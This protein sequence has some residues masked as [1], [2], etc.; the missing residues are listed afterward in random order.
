M[1]WRQWGLWTLRPRVLAGVLLVELGTVGWVVCAA[2]T[3]PLPTAEDWARLGALAAAALAH[4]QLSRRAEERRRS[5]GTKLHID[6]LSI[7]T[8][9]AALLLPIPLVAVLIGLTRW[10]RHRIARKPTFKAVLTG[11]SITLAACSAHSLTQAAGALERGGLVEGVVVLAAA[12]V[13]CVQQLLLIGVVILLEA[14]QRPPLSQVFGTP[15]QWREMYLAISLGMAVALA[16]SH[17][18]L[19]VVMVGVG[20]AINRLAGARAQAEQAVRLAQK[21]AWTDPLTQV[22]N[23]AGWEHKA[24]DGLRQAALSGRPRAVVLVDLDHFKKVNDTLGHL[25]GDEVLQ[26]AAQ[27]I[28]DRVRGGDQVARFGGEEFVVALP[29]ADVDEARQVAERLLQGIRDVRVLATRL[30]GGDPVIVGGADWPCTASIGVAVTASDTDPAVLL[31]QADEAMYEAKHTGRNKV[32]V[33][34][35]PRRTRAGIA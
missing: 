5:D 10:Q 27:A 31:K 29:D 28:A 4:V 13:F 2:L 15:R 7:W 9:P 22:L 16:H 32:V 6:V 33:A 3:G 21:A 25:C 17:P 34:G 35:E 11:C 14:D 18:V 26:Q 19:V 12:A 30:R 24:L 8:F 20:T 23:K 1:N